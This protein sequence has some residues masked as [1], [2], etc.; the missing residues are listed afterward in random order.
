VAI[1]PQP[2]AVAYSDESELVV[3][4]ISTRNQPR[5]QLL[6]R[7]ETAIPETLGEIAKKNL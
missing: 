7:I 5:P 4:I 2:F 1:L 6:K 3:A